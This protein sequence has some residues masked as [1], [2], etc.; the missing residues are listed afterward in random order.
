[1]SNQKVL[2]IA[3]LPH[4]G[5]TLTSL[6]LGH[7]PNMIGVGSLDKAIYMIS[8]N[9]EKESAVLCTCGSRVGDCHFW[10]SFVSNSAVFRDVDFVSRYS[11]AIQYF[12]SSFGKNKWLVDSSKLPD[13]IKKIHL[14]P[15]TSLHGLHIC[16]DFR[17]SIVSTVDLKRKNKNLSRPGWII[18]IEAAIRWQRRNNA[19]R[20]TLSENKIPFLGFGYEEIC[21]GL[22]HFAEQVG[23]FLNNDIFVPPATILGSR[24]HISITGNPM[25]NQKEKQNLTYDYRW[26][27]RKDWIPA[28]L[29]M[30]WL[31]ECNR[32]W[33]YSNAFSKIFG[34]C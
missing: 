28:S 29:L 20:N 31:H 6:L 18:G 5:S 23:I 25:R 22:A 9:P 10:S 2:F 24:S 8:E 15:N 34:K 14:V 17:S 32:R 3:C 21:L 12:Q 7:L 11:S 26:F 27:S 4:S 19:I 30:P 1:M 16:R 13:Q 33:V